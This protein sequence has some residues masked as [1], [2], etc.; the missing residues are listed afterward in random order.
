MFEGKPIAVQVLKEPE[1]M[2][3][4]SILVMIRCWNPSTWEISPMKELLVKRYSTLD[5]FSHILAK[6]YP[7]IDRKNIECCKV[8]NFFRVQLPYEKWF[9]LNQNENFLASNPFYLSTDGLLLIIKD[10]TIP[11]RELTEEEKKQFGCD[12]YENAIFATTG[13][14]KRGYAKEKAMKINVKKKKKNKMDDFEIL[15]PDSKPPKDING[16]SETEVVGEQKDVDMDQDL[17]C[18]KDTPTDTTASDKIPNGVDLKNGK[19]NGDCNG[20]HENGASGDAVMKE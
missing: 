3:P 9:E 11:E 18:S 4:D 16:Q 10:K 14:G 13:G 20:N 12:E 19:T 1:T 17:G 7:E 5:D 6:E 15:V 8:N 2:D